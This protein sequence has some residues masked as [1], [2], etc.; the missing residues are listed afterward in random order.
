MKKLKLRYWCQDCK[1]MH[2]LDYCIGHMSTE[3]E[4]DGD[5]YVKSPTLENYL[6]NYDMIPK[7]ILCPNCSTRLNAESYSA[8]YIDSELADIIEQMNEL[9]FVTIFCCSGHRLGDQCYILCEMNDEM[10]M[11]QSVFMEHLAAF[12]MKYP[13]T[14]SSGY[15][16][17]LDWYNE[18]HRIQFQCLY[19]AAPDENSNSDEYLNP[20]DAKITNAIGY[21][22]E[23]MRNSLY[24]VRIS[25]NAILIPALQ[26]IM[27][28]DE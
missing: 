5:K 25:K 11:F 21:F 8:F 23:W 9:G 4:W 15:E 19:L 24:E 14:D 7:A 10:R 22:K 6:L 26:Q 1:T 18:K 13:W 17:N 3:N 2:E 12:R 27:T 20:Y 28:V 16:A